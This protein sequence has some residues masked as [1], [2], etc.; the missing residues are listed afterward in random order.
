MKMTIK[1]TKGKYK[2]TASIYRV[3]RY[4]LNPAKNPHNISNIEAVTD[5]EIAKIVDSFKEV[6]REY[7]K[8]SGK[9]ILHFFVTFPTN[10]N[11]SYDSYLKIAF[12]IADYFEYHQLIFAMHELNKHLEPCAKHIHFAVNPINF[13]T[14]KRLDINKDNLKELRQC[15]HT[16]VQDSIPFFEE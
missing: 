10:A 6:Q 3:I 16:I 8:E 15:I 2:S 1:I 13:Y 11:L 5:K 14:G 12:D 4:I 9:R 7:R